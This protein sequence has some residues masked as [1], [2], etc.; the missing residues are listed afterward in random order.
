LDPRRPGDRPHPIGLIPVP[1]PGK[2]GNLAQVNAPEIFEKDPPTAASAALNPLPQEKPT[3]SNRTHE[4]GLTRSLGT[5]QVFVAGVALV[6]AAST[7]V[8]DFS[9]YFQLGA[10]FAVALGLG[11]LVNLALGLSAADLSVAHPRAGA[12]YD[13]ARA[14]IGG[15]RGHF[16]G[17]FLGLT[18]F[19]MFA[20]TASGE[21]A[22]GAY[23]LKALLGSDLPIGVF[24]VVLSVLAAVPN[25]LGIRTTAWVSAGL[26]LFMLGIRW[27]FGLAGFLGLGNTG[28]WSAANLDSG[29]GAFDWFGEGG[30]VTA[31][32]AL[33]FWSFVGIEFA[34]SLAEEVRKPRTAMPWGIVLGL[35][36]I[37]ATSLVMGLGVVGT[38]PLE[39]WRT[40]S[41]GAL[42]NGGDS[43]QLAVGQLM[44]GEAGF[45][46]M[47]LAS[48]AATLGTLTVA[49]AAIPRILFS[50]A[51]D[52]KFF[53]PLSKT[54]GTL[55]PRTQTPVVAILFTLAACLVPALF[56]ATV[57]EWLYSAAYVWIVL[58]IVFHLLALLNRVLHRDAERA[59]RGAW[60][61]PVTVVGAAAAAVCLYFAFAGAHAEYGLRALV[62][63][64]AALAASAVSFGLPARVRFRSRERTPAPPAAEHSYV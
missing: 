8:S 56:S 63:I 27:F 36:A 37:L 12:L 46:L 7:L 13:Y 19:G 3:M 14:V 18:F 25:I 35:L 10:A 9:G 1:P 6:V 40:A 48:V 24:I 23:G 58:Y 33:A 44:F 30:V 16:V 2:Y 38:A 60:F 43:P 49:F 50:I 59:F 52:G 31:G 41:A 55:H 20:F 45:L 54:F 61:M 51:R 17:V 29:V 15:R 64:L 21:T 47:A 5:W 53:G 22:A 28:A 26:L 42:G 34:C 4:N 39:V 57:V 11:F 32:L 62:V